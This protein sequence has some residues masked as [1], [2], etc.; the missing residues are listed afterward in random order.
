M[1]SHRR[2]ADAAVAHHDRRHAVVIRRRHPRRP[3]G[4]TV[5][6]RVD[7]DEARRHDRAGG[8]SISSRPRPDIV[9]TATILPCGDA[10]SA[11]ARRARRCRRRR[12]RR[13]SPDRVRHRSLLLVR[14]AAVRESAVPATRRC[15]RCSKAAP[16]RRRSSRACHRRSASGASRRPA[17]RARRP[18]SAAR[19][20]PDRTPRNRRP[21]RRA[22][23]R[24]RAGPTVVAV[25]Y[26]MSRTASSSVNACFSRTQC[27]SR[28]VCSELS[29]ICDTCAPESENVTTRARMLHHLEHVVLIFVRDRLAEEH[30]EVLSR[31][32]CRSSPR[33]DARRARARHPT[34]AA[35]RSTSCPSDRPSP[36]PAVAP[37]R[38]RCAVLCTA[39]SRRRRAR[40]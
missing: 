6:V 1:R 23:D 31:A 29:M 33:P 3:R 2:E 24:G 34:S 12:R 5:V 22:T 25:S 27:D 17:D 9:A 15:V 20:C 16:H 13:E 38:R 18:A 39:P 7:V 40:V 28:C 8:R 26:V 19:P 4:L 14:C 37:R 10:T 32:R 21:C 11:R 36:N 30:L 35:D